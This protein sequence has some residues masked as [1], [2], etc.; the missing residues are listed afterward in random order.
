M[1]EGRGGN[2][3]VLPPVLTGPVVSASPSA[4]AL[5]VVE[6]ARGA[7]AAGA[8]RGAL[9]ALA[10]VVRSIMLMGVFSCGGMVLG[11]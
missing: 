9:A 5:A 2:A 8:R 1:E 4:M 6:K 7:K 3:Y 11:S 10:I